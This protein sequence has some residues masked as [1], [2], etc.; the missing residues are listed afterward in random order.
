MLPA[1]QPSITCVGRPG[2]D[3]SPTVAE[4]PGDAVETPGQVNTSSFFRKN[5]T[6]GAEAEIEASPTSGLNG[7]WMIEKQVRKQQ[8]LPGK[9]PRRT[10]ELRTTST[11]RLMGH[12]PITLSNASSDWGSQRH[13]RV[14][15]K[16]LVSQ[17]N[18]KQ[19]PDSLQKL[20]QMYPHVASTAKLSQW[21]ISA[22]CCTPS[23][24][25][26]SKSPISQSSKSWR[27]STWS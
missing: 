21:A 2:T 3:P 6:A 4:R 15:V 14:R 17:K 5:E 23:T 18:L 22:M 11:N 16:L 1:Y 13:K 26:A 19:K 8:S 25:F 10:R 24:L 20:A 9:R 27:R 7:P 12:Q